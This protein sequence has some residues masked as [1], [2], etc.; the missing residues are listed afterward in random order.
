VLEENMADEI[1]VRNV[2]NALDQIEKWVRAV[3]E[4]VATLPK[5]Q[6]MGGTS[7]YNQWKRTA[8]PPLAGDCHPKGSSTS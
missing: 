1:K 8:P 3:R 2:L 4:A 6:V 5:D 7:D